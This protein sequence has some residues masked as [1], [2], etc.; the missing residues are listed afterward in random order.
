MTLKTSW[1]GDQGGK[2][3]T[4]EGQPSVGQSAKLLE[5]RARESRERAEN[6]SLNSLKLVWP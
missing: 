4:E 1:G 5:V 2:L 6:A 3:R